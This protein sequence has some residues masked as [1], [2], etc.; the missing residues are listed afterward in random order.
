[1]SKREFQLRWEQMIKDIE[2]N[3]DF[4]ETELFKIGNQKK[5]DSDEDKLREELKDK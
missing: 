2:D 3:A 4:I 5:A 1:M